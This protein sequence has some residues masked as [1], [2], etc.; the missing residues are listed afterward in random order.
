MHVC[1][2]IDVRFLLG[3]ASALIETRGGLL[4]RMKTSPINL[5]KIG[6]AKLLKSAECG[7]E[8]V[9]K[10]LLCDKRSHK[11]T[12]ATFGRL[13]TLGVAVH[14][15]GKRVVLCERKV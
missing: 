2:H 10:L 8:I 13:T 1:V 9:E 14:M 3:S 15:G 4:I 6:P 5:G 7:A 12:K 11:A